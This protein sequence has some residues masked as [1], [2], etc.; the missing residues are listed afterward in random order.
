MPRDGPCGQAPA[1]LR[2]PARLVASAALNCVFHPDVPGIGICVSCRRVV[3]DACS[4]R[5]Q[6]RNFCSECLSGRAVAGRDEAGPDSPALVRLALGMLALACTG[7]LAALA[8]AVGFSL[9]LAG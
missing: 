5:L 8:S 1:P 6:G 7:L 9:Y 4:T 2:G 3:C